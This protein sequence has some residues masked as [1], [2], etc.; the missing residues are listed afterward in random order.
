MEAPGASHTLLK[1]FAFYP[2]IFLY[3]ITGWSTSGTIL[4]PAIS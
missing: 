2:Y 4:C 3:Q 1:H